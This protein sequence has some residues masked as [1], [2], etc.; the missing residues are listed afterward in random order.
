MK[1]ETSCSPAQRRTQNVSAAI[2]AAALHRLLLLEHLH[3]W[4]PSCQLCEQRAVRRWSGRSVCGQ[5][6][7]RHRLRGL[8]PTLRRVMATLASTFATLCAVERGMR[9][10]RR[11]RWLHEWRGLGALLWLCGPLEQHA[12]LLLCDR[13]QLMRV[14]IHGLCAA[15]DST[16]YRLHRADGESKRAARAAHGAPPGA[17]ALLPLHQHVRGRQRGIHSRRLLRRRWRWIIQWRL[18]HRH[19]L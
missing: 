10:H 13:R 11:R 17:S 15:G 7:L 8:R 14:G 4:R 18:C 6:R 19:R 2:A 12:C 9:V 16:T 3:R 1:V 5:L